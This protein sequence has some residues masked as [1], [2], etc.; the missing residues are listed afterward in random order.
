M[1][2]QKIKFKD[3]VK[4]Y[5]KNYYSSP[6]LN[7]PLNGSWNPKRQDYL[8][9]HNSNRKSFLSELEEIEANSI[10]DLV[11]KDFYSYQKSKLIFS[12]FLKELV[13]EINNNK[14]QNQILTI[15][16]CSIIAEQ[17]EEY[18][19]IKRNL[20]KY[21]DYIKNKNFYLL[22]NSAKNINTFFLKIEKS[23][24]KIG[25]LKKKFGFIKQKYFLVN[26]EIYLKKQKLNNYRN[27][28]NNLIK[29]REY[30]RMYLFITNKKTMNNKIASNNKSKFNK[31]LELIKNIEKFKYYNKSLIC[32]W[33]IQ[34]LKINKNDYID[35]YEELL[36]K[37]FLTKINI[38]EFNSLYD[39]FTSINNLNNNNNNINNIN[40]IK[41]NVK[42]INDDLLNKLVIYLKKNI[43]NVFK[44][45]LL[46]YA[47]IDYSET[48]N[49]N[50]ILKLKQLQALSFEETK[51]FLAINQICLT[52]INLCDNLH[53]YIFNKEYRN[54]KFGQ[55]FYIN[56]KK[57]YDVLNKKLRKILYLYTD[58]IINFQDKKNIYL[59][60]SSFSLIYTYIEKTFQINNSPTI[61]NTVNIN[62]TTNK[63]NK[64]MNPT[65][66][67][68]K[69]LT[70]K[71]FTSKNNINNNK[72]LS[73][74]IIIKTNSKV[75][76]NSINHNLSK[77]INNT[78]N[79][80]NLI[81]NN[82]IIN[83]SD[84]I[85]NNNII[86]NNGNQMNILKKEIY[87]FFIKLTSFELKQNIKNL[88]L[89]LNKDNWK[90]IN[91]INIQEQINKKYIKIIKYK[92]FINLP[93]SNTNIDKN[94]IK[95]H[96]TNLS[97]FKESK[98]IKLTIN[99]LLNKKLNERNLVF[100][101][102]SF[103][104]LFYIFEF[105]SYGL[106]IPNIKNKIISD[107]F[108]LYDY[109]IYSSILMFN[110]DKINIQKLQQKKI[111]K[112][113]GANNR[114]NNNEMSYNDLIIIS[115]E[116][117]YFQNY[118]NL[119]PYLWHCKNQVLIKIFGDEK[120]L[121]TILPSLS[122]IL[123]Q[124]NNNNNDKNNINVGHFMEKIIC[125]ENYW[126]LFKIIKRIINN[127]IY[128]TQINKYKIILNEIRHFFY[129]PICPNLIRNKTYINLFVNN[130]WVV[131]TKINNKMKENVY[132]QIILDNLKDINDKLNMFL[133]ISLKGIIRFVY[134]FLNVMINKIKDNFEKIKDINQQGIN[135]MIMDF[136][137]LQNKI[138]E[139]INNNDNKNGNE[140]NNKLN[141]AIFE[142]IFNN[143]Y[144]FFNI[145]ITNKNLF[146]N[147]VGKNR[148]PLYL[149]NTLLN[150]NKSISMEDKNKIKIDL[151]CNCIKE[152][153]IIDKILKKY[154]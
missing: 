56:R 137:A 73:N 133:P 145:T 70:K 44:G 119:I 27:I 115:K 2:S 143:L 101:S 105:I 99:K 94:E 25:V 135:I 53:I 82:N 12:N 6:L 124:N 113:F 89:Y 107:I 23:L 88:A 148:I 28:Y 141:N 106:I 45:I 59:I 33:F 142:D 9:Q 43:L 20:I 5:D 78:K 123:L 49:S 85:S 138:Y 93:F 120:I 72:K 147:N 41:K 7:N 51:L 55:L 42:N 57:F 63:N 29:L 48:Q 110:Y 100:S 127:D 31:N 1:S 112:E 154:N 30:K 14:K 80:N 153:E 74:N 75:N 35:N 129:S 96:L 102:S 54:T 90:K 22:K 108:N 91:V 69:I 126:S 87:N 17:K 37:I 34:N 32:F 152:M 64:I 39:I 83:N 24:L 77:V 97:N 13:N 86:N 118:M 26:S 60:L 114:K 21:I 18:E 149:I 98:E 50:A 116:M 131:N 132:I 130:N 103:Y 125:F 8:K 68:N 140:S 66:N 111:K 52:I 95:K 92:S 139:F 38:D 3:F 81:N 117:E 151:K 4:F 67:N 46:S 84:N 79:N 134:I 62:S 136:K 104:L 11:P 61:S 40:I 47:T 16:S 122:P 19:I 121:F 10:S 71:S 128:L 146:F 109:Y 150:L 15:D 76:N 65:Q 144:E 58:L 36:S